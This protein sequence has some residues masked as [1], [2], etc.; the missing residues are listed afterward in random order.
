MEQ[1]THMTMGKPHFS[2]THA[3][4]QQG[5]TAPV[6][7]DLQLRLPNGKVHSTIGTPFTGQTTLDMYGI[8]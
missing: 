4:H 5:C 3:Q 6:Q 8:K 1:Q 2:N 7:Q